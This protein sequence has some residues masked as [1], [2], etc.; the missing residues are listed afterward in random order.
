MD[1]ETDLTAGLPSRNSAKSSTCTPM[2]TSGP[3]PASEDCVN[4]EPSVGMPV[5]RSHHAFV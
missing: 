2:S 3:P 1:A 5:R 4:H